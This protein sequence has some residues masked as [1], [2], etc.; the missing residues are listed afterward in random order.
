MWLKDCFQYPF[1]R[2]LYQ[3]I[4][5]T[6]DCYSSISMVS[7]DMIFRQNKKV[8]HTKDYDVFYGTFFS[9]RGIYVMIDSVA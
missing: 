4:L 1:Q 3:F 5:I 9:S 6:I 2:I 7:S 8:P